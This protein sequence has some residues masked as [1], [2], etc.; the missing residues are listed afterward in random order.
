MVTESPKRYRHSGRET[1]D[2][3]RVC[4]EM[5]ETSRLAALGRLDA[6]GRWSSERLGRHCRPEGMRIE[7]IVWKIETTRSG[8]AED[9]RHSSC[10]SASLV[11]AA[12][13]AI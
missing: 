6:G 8:D 3:G 13:D 1:G 7:A 12:G 10:S 11:E 2:P 4:L 5:N 9:F